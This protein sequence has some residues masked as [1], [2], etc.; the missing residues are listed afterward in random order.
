M[1]ML[2]QLHQRLLEKANH[3]LSCHLEL[4][5][6][7]EHLEKENQAQMNGGSEQLLHCNMFC[8]MSTS[9]LA[10]EHLDAEAK[11]LSPVPWKEEI[12]K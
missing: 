3:H 11:L 9:H 7:H 4:F 2:I 5:V 1:P 6:K 8:Y 10:S 12:Y